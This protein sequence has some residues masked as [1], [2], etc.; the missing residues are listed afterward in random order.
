M[1]ADGS[2]MEVDGK[3][4]TEVTIGQGKATFILFAP[5]VCMGMDNLLKIGPKQNL[6]IAV[7]ETK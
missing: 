5:E 1:Q 4:H 3:T 2:H 6:E 7:L